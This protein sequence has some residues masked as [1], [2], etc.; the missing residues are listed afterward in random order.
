VSAT[1]I[2]EALEITLPEAGVVAFQAGFEVWCEAV[3]AE[4]LEPSAEALAARDASA[5]D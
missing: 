2:L 5:R 1:E 4:P 3:G